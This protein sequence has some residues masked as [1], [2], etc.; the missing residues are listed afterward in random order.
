MPPCQDQLQ[1]RSSFARIFGRLE[2]QGAS[3]AC[4]IRIQEW[5]CHE[6]HICVDATDWV[7][8]HTVQ[9][10]VAMQQK[11][12]Q[13]TER[14]DRGEETGLNGTTDEAVEHFVRLLDWTAGSIQ[15]N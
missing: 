5:N 9:V 11:S 2:Y 4:E 12:K 15:C 3:T 13:V 8:K 10:C 14:K 1:S 6:T 7:G